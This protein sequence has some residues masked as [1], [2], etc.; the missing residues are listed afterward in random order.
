MLLDLVDRLGKV[1]SPAA[2]CLLNGLVTD[3]RS[4][5]TQNVDAAVRAALRLM[6]AG[7]S[8]SEVAWRSLSQRPLACASVGAKAID[9]LHLEDRC[10]GQK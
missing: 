9:G 5:R 2:T 1:T 4:F 3:T 8:P 7:A 6:E 10:S